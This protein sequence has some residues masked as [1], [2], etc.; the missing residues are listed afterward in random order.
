MLCLERIPG[1]SVAC[2]EEVLSTGT[3][4]GTPGVVLPFQKSPKFLIPIKKNLISLCCL[5]FHIEYRLTP[6]R[7]M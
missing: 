3:S 5:E 1:F 7:H 2:K 6:Q 4:R